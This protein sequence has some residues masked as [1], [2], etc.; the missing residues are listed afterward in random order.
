VTRLKTPTRD[1]QVKFLLLYFRAGGAPNLA[2]IEAM[3]QSVSDREIKDSVVHAISGFS[4]MGFSEKDIGEKLVSLCL[5]EYACFRIMNSKV[6]NKIL[7][8]K[9]QLTE[10]DLIILRDATEG[11]LL[12]GDQLELAQSILIEAGV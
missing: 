11:D 10:S 6:I 8:K 3:M 1:E 12:K 5:P 9:R 4:E 7:K 2:E